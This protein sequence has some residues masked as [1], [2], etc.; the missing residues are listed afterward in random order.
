MIYSFGARN[1]FSFKEGLNASFQLGARVPSDISNGRKIATVLGVKGANASGKTNI[2]KCLVFLRRFISQSFDF[3]EKDFI[4]FQSFFGDES[5]TDFYIDFEVGG[6]RYIYELRATRNEVLSEIL[7]KK[8]QRKTPIVERKG[9]SIVG[10]TKEYSSLDLVDLKSRASLIST[11]VKYKIKDM[12]DDFERIVSY[13]RSYFGNVSS[14]GVIPDDDIFQ[15]ASVTEFYNGVPE[16]FEFVKSILKKVDLGIVDI[17]IHESVNAQGETEYNPIFIHQ[18]GSTSEIRRLGYHN[19]SSGTQALYRRLSVYWLV[20]KNGGALV[21]DEFDQ[22]CHPML[23]PALL[24]LFSGIESNPKNAQFIFTAHN[25]DIIDS[26]GKYR[27]ILVAKEEGASYSYRLDE[28]PGDLIR[29]DRSIAALY[30]EGKIGGVPN[31]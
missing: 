2:L 30:R 17:E 23:L 24:D 4:H 26:L 25:A 7:Y 28:I 5:P 13:F 14:L 8:L 22:N 19:Q 31:L 11:A 3:D 18:V 27:T 16:A 20:L 12:P 15:R 9:N 10:R 29:N 1:Y 6:I 21:M